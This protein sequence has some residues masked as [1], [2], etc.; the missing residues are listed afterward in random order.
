[1][2]NTLNFLIIFLCF[3]T[4]LVAQDRYKY[5][6]KYKNIAIR[7]MERAGVPASIK[8][9]QGLLESG[10]GTSYLAKKANNHFGIKCGGYWKGRTVYREDDDYDENGQLEKSCFRAYKSAEESYIAHSEF[11]RNPRSEHRYGF[12]FRY[13]VT[14]YRRWARGLKKAGYA[15]SPTYADKLIRVIETYNLDQYDRLSSGD[16]RDIEYDDTD[17]IAGLDLR[18]INDVKVVY[19]ERDDTP[20]NISTKADV[21]LKCI[22]KYNEMLHEPATLLYRDELVFLQKKRKNFRGTKKWHYVREGE[23]MYNISQLYGIRLKN[24]YKRNRMPEGTQSE[25][26]ERIRIRG[27]KVSRKER[28]RLR[29]GYLEPARDKKSKQKSDEVDGFMDTE[30]TIEPE[31]PTTTQPNTSTTGSNNGN[32]T[33]GSGSN[34]SW[35][36]GNNSGNSSNENSSSG[37]GSTNTNNGN[38]TNSESSNTSPGSGSTNNSGGSTTVHPPIFNPNN[39]ESSSSSG[40]S[41]HAT[42]YVVLKG[43]TLYSLSRKYAA[44]VSDLKRWNG[45]NDNTIYPGDRLRVQ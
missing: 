21:N 9:A 31:M 1:M 32:S 42:Y 4:S 29:P 35:A 44:S 12:L 2:R 19:S 14:N 6:E 8:L 36:D 11:L 22:I 5:I 13:N 34:S 37:T 38:P 17:M 23:T 24:L 18:R 27:W 30:N 28:P 10:G 40:N 33:D 16:I 43:D 3:T 7:E 39:S 41:S 26:D 20:A 25:K 45:L 15:T